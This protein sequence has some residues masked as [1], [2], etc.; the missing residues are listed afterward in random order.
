MSFRDRAIGPLERRHEY[1]SRRKTKGPVRKAKDVTPAERATMTPEQIKKLPPVIKD[2]V[3]PEELAKFIKGSKKTNLLFTLSPNGEG[4][5]RNVAAHSWEY[6]L[7][8]ISMPAPEFGTQYH[9]TGGKPFGENEGM[10]DDYAGQRKALSVLLETPGVPEFMADAFGPG[11]RNADDRWAYRKKGL[12][13]NSVA[14]QKDVH[15]DWPEWE[16]L[17]DKVEAQTA[18]FPAGMVCIIA[19]GQWAPH[20]IPAGGH[21]NSGGMVFSLYVSPLNARQYAQYCAATMAHFKKEC[22]KI[23]ADKKN[24]YIWKRLGELRDLGTALRP[25]HLFAANIMYGMRPGLYPSEK[26][27]DVPQTYSPPIYGP[28]TGYRPDET[29]QVINP[30]EEIPRIPIEFRRYFAEVA[31]VLA[32]ERMVCRVS[33]LSYEYLYRTFGAEATRDIGLLFEDDSEGKEFVYEVPGSVIDPLT[34][35]PRV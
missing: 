30:A 27:I 13:E 1:A 33:E 29:L 20:S 4:G 32:G 12:V 2:P 6:C 17:E 24:V 16:R 23:D 21:S 35:K 34:G 22:T 31:A 18:V 11:W 3:T 19:L 5:R 26:V 7:M 28:Y 25:Q 8:P 10:I 15:R 14:L 9:V